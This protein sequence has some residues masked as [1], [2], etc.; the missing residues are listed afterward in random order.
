[1][2]AGFFMLVHTF[3]KISWSVSSLQ[4]GIAQAVGKYTGLFKSVFLTDRLDPP[5]PTFSAEIWM[6]WYSE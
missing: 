6:P 3:S 2:R 1:M 4:M 5:L